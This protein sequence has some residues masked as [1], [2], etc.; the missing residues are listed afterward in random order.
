MAKADWARQFGERIEEAIGGLEEDALAEDVQEAVDW[1]E[2]VKVILAEDPAIK[3]KLRDKITELVGN[4]IDNADSLSELVG[5]DN[6][7]FLQCLPKGT[8]VETLVSELLEPGQALRTALEHKIAELIGSKIEEASD[9]EE[10]TGDSDFDWL[11]HL[12]KSWSIEKMITELLGADEEIKKKVRAKVQELTLDK[13]DSLDDDEMPEWEDMLEILQIEKRVR[14]IVESSDEVK[15]KIAER[16]RELIASKIEEEFE[17]DETAGDVLK[18]LDVPAEIR[19]ILSDHQFKIQVLDQLAVAIRKFI[20]EMVQQGDLGA[21]LS[22]KI[23]SN[24]DFQVLLDRQV[25]EMLRDPEL[26]AALK[27]SIKTRITNDSSLG[28]KLLDAVLAQVASS[29][30]DKL[31]GKPQSF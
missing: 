9:F 25:S 13:L 23:G 22:E 19:R 5:N 12:P 11:E 24:P 16:I 10:L 7:D 26:V 8:D 28:R 14:E 4:H 3:Q 20:L 21:E 27:S 6:F 30:I 15:S 2:L 1:R 18:A 29:L 31:T 17:D